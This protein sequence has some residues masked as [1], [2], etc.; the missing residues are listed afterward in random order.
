MDIGT[1]FGLAVT[2]TV[3]PFM[4]G[5]KGAL[6]LLP[7]PKLENYLELSRKLSSKSTESTDR[8]HLNWS[9]SAYVKYCS[10]A[11]VSLSLDYLF[12]YFWQVDIC[13]PPFLFHVKLLNVC[14]D[15][16]F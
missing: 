8:R 6:D 13:V 11:F 16:L 3:S 12:I 15:F 7:C 9:S 10:T 4:S 1:S 14:I 5:G 2:P